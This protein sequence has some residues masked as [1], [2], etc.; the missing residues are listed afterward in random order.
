[1]YNYFYTNVRVRERFKQ[2]IHDTCNPPYDE[3]RLNYRFEIG[4]RHRHTKKN[5]V[6]GADAVANVDL[7]Y[8]IAFIYP[9]TA[10]IRD[11]LDRGQTLSLNLCS[12]LAASR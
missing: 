8:A 6:D 7:R 4:R 11:F 2:W 3:E 12:L 10:T 1:V 5:E 9:I